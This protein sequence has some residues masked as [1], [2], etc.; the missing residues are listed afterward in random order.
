[1]FTAALARPAIAPLGDARSLDDG[2]DSAPHN[3]SGGSC[4]YGAYARADRRAGH[5]SFAGIRLVSCRQSQHGCPHTHRS[6]QVHR[7]TPLFDE[8]TIVYCAG[9]VRRNG[10]LRARGRVQPQNRLKISMKYG[11]NVFV[12]VV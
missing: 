12:R 5:M 11:I 4:D 8:N 3:G 10:Q 7:L 1:M 9:A 6:A 2:A